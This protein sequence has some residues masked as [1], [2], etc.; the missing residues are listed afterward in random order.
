MPC[1][2]FLEKNTGPRIY[3]THNAVFQSEIS[4]RSWK[5]N[6]DTTLTLALCSLYLNSKGGT[7]E[8]EF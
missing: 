1:N 2:I 4:V 7:Y 5:L 8:R 6:V 3:C